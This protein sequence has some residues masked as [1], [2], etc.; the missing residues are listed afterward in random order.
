MQEIRTPQIVAL[1]VGALR[2]QQPFECD[3]GLVDD[4]LMSF[5]DEET[6]QEELAGGKVVERFDW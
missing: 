2:A 1:N 5:I 4:R 6:D 3:Y